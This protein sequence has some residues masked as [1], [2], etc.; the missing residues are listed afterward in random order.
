[1]LRKY[2]LFLKKYPLITAAIAVVYG[3]LCIK[4]LKADNNLCPSLDAIGSDDVFPLSDL[5]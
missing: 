1:M 3:I 2:I 4:L 5:R